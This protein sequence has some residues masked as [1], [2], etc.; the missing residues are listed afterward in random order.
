MQPERALSV[1]QRGRMPPEFPRQGLARRGGEVTAAVAQAAHAG[2]T[3]AQ[4]PGLFRRRG[5]GPMHEVEPSLFHA[6]CF[7]SRRMGVPTVVDERRCPPARPAIRP[8]AAS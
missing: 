1:L 6:R 5:A 4:H 2:E 8:A 3:A 7:T